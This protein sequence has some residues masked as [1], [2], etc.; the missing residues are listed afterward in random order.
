MGEY[1]MYYLHTLKPYYVEKARGIA[2]KNINVEIMKAVKVPVPPLNAQKAI[3]DRIEER[4][5]VIRELE[6]T[7]VRALQI[8]RDILESECGISCVE[9]QAPK[10]S[11]ISDFMKQ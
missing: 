10:E 3:A 8:I 7:K 6:Q 1:L 9:S 11:R 5:L 2:Q 4:K